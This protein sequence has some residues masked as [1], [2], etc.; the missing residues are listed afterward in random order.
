MKKKASFSTYMYP[1]TPP[2]PQHP[3][4]SSPRGRGG[5]Y[6][7][8]NTA[9]HV[10]MNP[11]RGSRSKDRV[12]DT[13]VQPSPATADTSSFLSLS[14]V[15]LKDRV[16]IFEK[17][18]EETVISFE[19]KEK[20]RM[21]EIYKLRKEWIEHKVQ[22]NT[23]DRSLFL[24][25]LQVFEKYCEL[26]KAKLELDKLH[27][28][29]FYET[30]KLKQLIILTK[31]KESN[32]V[33]GNQ[34][35]KEVREMMRA[36]ANEI[37]C[38]LTESIIFRQKIANDCDNS[39]NLIQ[40]LL[41]QEKTIERQRIENVENELK[42][43][44][45]ELKNQYIKSS[46]NYKTAIGEYLILR[47]NS[48]IAQELLTASINEVEKK[49]VSLTKSLKAAKLHA[50]EKI[51]SVEHSNRSELEVRLRHHRNEVVKYET[52][53]E[54]LWISN[55]QSRF[56]FSVRFKELK[57][58]I[59]NYN[60]KFTSLQERRFHELTVVSTELKKMNQVLSEAE[61]AIYVPARKDAHLL[62]HVKQCLHEINQVVNELPLS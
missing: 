21:N 11:I 58:E 31:P 34:R 52:E 13:G 16:E 9:I 55:D 30:Q 45:G 59:E 12:G 48:K 24:K 46:S 29:G 14:L 35:D 26:Y 20:E 33:T 2:Q 36:S 57:E 32:D 23:N 60:K 7:H 47:H 19:K 41:E 43:C 38:A 15:Y 56:D 39:R 28:D 17:E 49:K 50:A 42:D 3:P 8:A 44:V 27:I 62:E 25:K 6:N 1:Q 53:M 22:E 10:N 54:Q 4:N 61:D 40:Q 51:A 18:Y 5:S 37:K